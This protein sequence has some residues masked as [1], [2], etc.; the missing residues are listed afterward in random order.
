M[1]PEALDNL[2]VSLGHLSRQLWD[3]QAERISA[4]NRVA[5]MQRDGVAADTIKRSGAIVPALKAIEAD[6]DA[7]IRRVIRL[8]PLAPWIMAQRGIGMPTF[9]S[10][11]GVTGD[12]GRFSTVSKLWKYLGLHVTPEGLAPKKKKGEGWTHTDCQHDHLTTCPAACTTNHH[13]NCA[14]GV[15]GTAYSPRGRTIACFHIGEMGI[16]HQPKGSGPYRAAYDAKKAYYED[17]REEWPQIRRHKAA[18]RY[19]TKCFIRDLWREWM[20]V[21]KPE[22]L[23]EWE[24]RERERAATYGLIPTFSVQPAPDFNLEQI[25]SCRNKRQYSDKSSAQA[26]IV[27]MRCD[28][29]PDD[30]DAYLCRFCDHWHVGHPPRRQQEQK[31]G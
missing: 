26:A 18:L 16:G 13:P 5:A 19:A 28:G 15:S 11:L 3:L 7:D 2:H 17:Q 1:T 30:L 21:L 24:A 25:K 12:I 22:R 27:R 14:P 20:R 29:I 23:E 8:H 4:G 9:A 6:I 10:L 31:A